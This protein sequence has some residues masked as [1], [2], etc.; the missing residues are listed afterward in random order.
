MGV[1]D[2]LTPPGED[3]VLEALKAQIVALLRVAEAAERDVTDAKA[4]CGYYA[5][6]PRC[7]GPQY[8][9]HCTD[10]PYEVV[11]ETDMALAEW[12]RVREEDA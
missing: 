1:A 9:R 12:R 3:S 5:D 11:R 7:Y 6:V 4:Q 2:A 10:C 8:K